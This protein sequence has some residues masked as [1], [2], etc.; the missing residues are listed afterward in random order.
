MNRF[1]PDALPAPDT[2][3]EFLDPRDR[4]ASLRDQVNMADPRAIADRAINSIR[5][6]PNMSTRDAV[7]LLRQAADLLSGIT[8]RATG[9][10]RFAALQ[11]EGRVLDN[12]NP[13]LALRTNRLAISG[14]PVTVPVRTRP[15]M[16]NPEMLSRELAGRTMAT[17]QGMNNAELTDL[18]EQMM[19]IN[20]SCGT[21]WR[22]VRL[23]GST[24]PDGEA[25]HDCIW[26]NDPRQQGA[27]LIIPD[28]HTQ[29]FMRNDAEFSARGFRIRE[30]STWNAPN[31]ELI[32]W[33]LW[34]QVPRAYPGA[35]MTGGMGMYPQPLIRADRTFPGIGPVPPP[36][37]R[38]PLPPPPP[39]FRPGFPGG[40]V[41]FPGTRGL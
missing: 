5:S 6:N 24:G 27:Y 41:R 13:R 21:N 7:A 26:V 34:E 35:F 18:H 31:G 14:E 30:H 25:M 9:S 29:E 23:R 19:A 1:N 8:D 36:G 12:L 3:A 33:V 10:R 15:Y 11:S 40:P 39:G 22:P 4:L 28:M 20:R 32:H 16:G 17:F 38:G 2:G 37:V